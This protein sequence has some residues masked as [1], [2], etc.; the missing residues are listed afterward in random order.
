MTNLPLSTWCALSRDGPKTLAGSRIV[1][2]KACTY[3]A[4][5]CFVHRLK[6]NRR[7]QYNR[8][9]YTTEQTNLLK[10]SL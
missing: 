6:Q 1:T 8:H 10:V 3:G 5:I 2:I 4:E 7:Q 9:Y